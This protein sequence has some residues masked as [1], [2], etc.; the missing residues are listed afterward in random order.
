MD[1]KVNSEVINEIEIALEKM[2]EGNIEEN[3]IPLDACS[4]TGNLWNTNST[5]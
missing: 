3:V 1:N 2:I 5:R 4:C